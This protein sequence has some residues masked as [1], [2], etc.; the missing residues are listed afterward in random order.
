MNFN[1]TYT[2]FLTLNSLFFEKKKK[3]IFTRKE[4]KLFRLIYSNITRDY[5]THNK[6]TIYIVARDSVDGE[7]ETVSDDFAAPVNVVDHDSRD[8]CH[9][10]T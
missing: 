6:C 7:G 2:D 9:L 1:K 4:N 3:T 5:C 8:W 10:C